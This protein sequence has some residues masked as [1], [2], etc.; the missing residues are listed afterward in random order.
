MITHKFLEYCAIEEPELVSIMK[1]K[2]DQ[3]LQFDVGNFDD[4]PSSNTDYTD[5][6][7]P[8]PYTILQ[9]NSSFAGESVTI[10]LMRIEREVGDAVMYVAQRYKEEWTSLPPIIIKRVGFQFTYQP[11]GEPEETNILTVRTYHTAALKIF[12]IMGCS[13]ITTQNHPAPAALN[14]KRIKTGKPP[15]YE[16][17]TLVLTLD[18][19]SKPG[20]SKG[21]TH[22]SPRV[23]LRR[24][25]IRK[26]DDARRVWVQAC[27]VVGSG[28]GMVAKDYKIKSKRSSVEE[29]RT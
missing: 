17:K 11:V 4:L 7:P 15:L 6:R 20:E 25:H 12:Y 18:A 19:K 29:R 5:A 2:F 27:V 10:L 14:K 22:S 21:G 9:F 13:N 16:Y 8:F 24:G 26:L 1:K 28:S 3:C 23:H